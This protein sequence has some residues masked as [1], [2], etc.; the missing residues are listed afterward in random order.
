MA[1]RVVEYIIAAKDRTALAVRSALSRI[2]SFTT[3]VGRNLA[4]LQAGFGMT[5]GVVRTF[6]GIVSTAIAEAF[7]FERAEANFRSLLGSVDRAKA[8]I[9]DLREFANSTPLTFDD[10]SR[11]SRLLLSFGAA[12]DSVLPSLKMLGD[13]S[14]GNAQRF[15]GL[16]LV[17]AQVQSQGKLM[18][19]DLLQM[20]NQGFNPLTVI[21]KETGATVSELKD[22]MAEGG[23]SF[24]MVAAAMRKATEEGGL[25]HNALQEASTT[26]EGL[27]STLK[28]KWTNAVA[29]FGMA[30]S[31]AAK[32]GIQRLIDALDDLVSSG[33]ID[34]WAS[35][36]VEKI[37]AVGSAFA[38]IGDFFGGIWKGVKGTVGT[39]LA[40][41][42]GADEARENGEGLWEQLKAGGRVARQMWNDTWNP[43]EDPFERA[44]DNEIRLSARQ[45]ATA[46]AVE[47]VRAEQAA[48]EESAEKE[49]SLADMLADATAEK[50]RKA[51]E[52]AAE[53][54]R[55]A[56]EAAARAEE[57]ERLRIERAVAAERDRLLRRSAQLQQQELAAISSESAAA[58]NALA[59]AQAES[60]RAWGWYRNRDSLA[61]QL[62]EERAD[63][64]ARAQFQ[65]DFDRLRSRRP[66]WRTAADYDPDNFRSLSLGETAV[67]RVA[68]AR[69]EEERVREWQRKTAEATERAA[70]ALEQIQ[71]AL[72]ND[73]GAFS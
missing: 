22:L 26:G 60:S 4:N 36:A 66:D 30:F 20:V 63:A 64:A 12:A 62:D 2:K 57:Q 11:A 5:A 6:A 67:K 71:D 56:A 33:D 53:A 65:R 69:E 31:D 47:Q 54:E 50:R 46:R 48:R 44:A 58:D 10:L 14:M 17:F 72:E 51:A 55:K 23:I 49:K 68:L 18:G 21:A 61:A 9:A 16:A 25:F 43:Q 28:D 7:R 34:V 24:E 52:A 8:H 15:Q 41:G 27:I 3:G 59:A 13:I 40:F 39:A 32:G 29:Q 1:N 73:Q 42:A 70:E 37:G 38:A 19:Q 45:R 35:N